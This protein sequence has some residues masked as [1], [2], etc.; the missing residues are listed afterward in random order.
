VTNEEELVSKDRFNNQE[1]LNDTDATKGKV[2]EEIHILAQKDDSGEEV[3]HA[4]SEPSEQKRGM[5]LF[6]LLLPL[7]LVALSTAG[8]LWVILFP[9]YRGDYFMKDSLNYYNF[10]SESVLVAILDFAPLFLLYFLLVSTRCYF[11]KPL[12]GL[13]R[14][15]SVITILCI[16]A[17][18]DVFFFDEK[19]FIKVLSSLYRNVEPIFGLVKVLIIVALFKACYIILSY[20]KSKHSVKTDLIS[21]TALCLVYIVICSFFIREGGLIYLVHFSEKYTTTKDFPVEKR[22]T[23]ESFLKFAELNGYK[24][25]RFFHIEKQISYEDLLTMAAISPAL[26]SSNY[27]INYP[28]Y[29]ARYITNEILYPLSNDLAQKEYWGRKLIVSSERV[30]DHFYNRRWTMGRDIFLAIKYLSILSAV[31]SGNPEAAYKQW[32]RD[33]SPSL[34]WESLSKEPSPQM[35]PEEEKEW[36]YWYKVLWPQIE[37]VIDSV[38]KYFG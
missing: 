9:S 2:T 16:W 37:D 7:I 23:L 21:C 15:V 31:A 13:N 3:S 22:S 6:Y 33:K 17:C 8:T 30:E 34:R 29:Y 24:R 5:V 4:C 26:L 38:D 14:I 28:K 11:E 10:L 36:F 20:S 12:S 1:E 27:M 32:I 19:G 18:I 35:T 25:E